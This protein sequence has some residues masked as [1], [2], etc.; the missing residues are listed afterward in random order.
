MENAKWYTQTRLSAWRSASLLPLCLLAFPG[1]AEDDSV[2]RTLEELRG[3]VEKLEGRPLPA[4]DDEGRRIRTVHGAMDARVGGGFTAIAQGAVSNPAQFGGDHAEGSLSADLYF[5]LPVID[6]GDFLLRVDLQ[7]GAGL[8]RLPPLFTAPN[9]N[10]TGTNAD[11]E[12]WS[13]TDLHINEARYRHGLPG[14][15]TELLIGHMDLTAYFDNNELAN[16][17]TT[18][19]LAQQFVNNATVDWGGNDNFF[20]PGAVI[21]TRPSP[22]VEFAFGWFEG[23]GDYTDMFMHP[24]LI[25]QVTL[26][27]EQGGGEAYYRLYVWQRQT[28]HCRSSANPAVFADCALLDPAQQVHLGNSNSGVGLSVDRQFSS[29]WGIWA[30]VGYQDP[31]VAQFD[32]TISAGAVSRGL[33]KR[34]DRLGLAY[35][36]SLPSQPYKRATGHADTEHYFEIYYK[37]VLEGDGETR[38]MHV[39]PDLQII[40]APAGDGAVNPVVVPGVR[41]QAH[42]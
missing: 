15:R 10:P 18:Q 31:L 21:L 19:Y 3:R 33:F 30:R 4:G 34:P 6:R 25:G 20:G 22:A 40:A 27:S 38:G 36:A 16:D 42:F 23:D 13:G 17:E 29:G 14:N 41:F 12:S 24:F 39:S 11:I 37:H 35:G 8:T 26:E 1:Q 28:P 7:Q 2:Q 9:G 5:E 32:K